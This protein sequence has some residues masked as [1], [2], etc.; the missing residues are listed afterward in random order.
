[1]GACACCGENL[2]A[3]SPP[4]ESPLWVVLI[5]K[6]YPPGILGFPPGGNDFRKQES[7]SRYL[8]PHLSSILCKQWRAG[9]FTFPHPRRRGHNL[10]TE[11][12]WQANNLALS[13]LAVQN[14]IH[15]LR[16]NS[17]RSSSL[18]ARNNTLL[19]RMRFSQPCTTTSLV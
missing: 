2:V 6:K 8:L 10:K 14:T 17:Y 5:N 7:N 12:T 16:R 13:T 18:F 4:G 15:T 1:M 19:V 3:S 11:K 9:V